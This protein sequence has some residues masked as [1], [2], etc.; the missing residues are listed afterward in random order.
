MSLIPRVKRFEGR[1]GTLLSD[2]DIE[3]AGERY[4]TPADAAAAIAG[5]R[6]NGMWF[7]LVSQEPKR[8]L[9]AVKR[10][11]LERIAGDTGV[12]DDEGDED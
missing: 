12:E 3:V 11:Y 9:G 1:V 6:R 2:G 7:F 8:S 5:K 10:E 4:A